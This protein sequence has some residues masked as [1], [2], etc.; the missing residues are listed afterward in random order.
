MVIKD[1]ENGET[2]LSGQRNCRRLN[3]KSHRQELIMDNEFKSKD[4]KK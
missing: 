3:L 1:V 2:I 4:S